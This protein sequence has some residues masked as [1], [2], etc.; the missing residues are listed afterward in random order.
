M[1]Q[2]REFEKSGANGG[3]ILISADVFKDVRHMLMDASDL[4]EKKRRG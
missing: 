3:N 2:P 4:N 1:P